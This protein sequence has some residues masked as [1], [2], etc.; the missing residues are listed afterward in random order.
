M[1]RPGFTLL[2]GYV[3]DGNSGKPL[4]GATVRVAP[5]GA[6]AKSDAKGHF[7][8]SVPTPEPENPGGMGVDTL[9]CEKT[10]QTDVTQNVG[11]VGEAMGPAGCALEKGSGQIIHDDTHK[12]MEDQG[13]GVGEEPQ[14]ARSGETSLSPELQ[15]WLG[16]PGTVFAIGTSTNAATAQAITVPASIALGTG[17]SSDPAKLYQPCSS[18]HGCSNVV[19]ILLET[20]VSNGLPGEWY[21]SWECQRYKGRFRRVSKLRGKFG[22]APIVPIRWCN[23]KR[24]ALDLHCSLRHL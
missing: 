8:L 5:G 10:G 18:K 1:V 6:E 17:G 23:C 12:P 19:K 14:S 2:H 24:W 4:P 11:I 7:Y 13:T 22:R 20:Y 3:E 21:A 16:N 15:N 9:I